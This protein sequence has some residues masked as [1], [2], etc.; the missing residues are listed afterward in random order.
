M[1]KATGCWIPELTGVPADLIHTPWLMT[2]AQKARFGGTSYIDPVCDQEQAAR[3]ARK[4]V[5]E[6]R[7]QHVSEEET[8]RVLKQ[9]G[10]RKGPVQ[11]RPTVPR[12]RQRNPRNATDN[13]LSL[14]D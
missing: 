6:F 3:A 8:G 4:A 5:G 2:L 7:K 11:K 14:F 12:K 9:H 10:S 13:Q 1:K